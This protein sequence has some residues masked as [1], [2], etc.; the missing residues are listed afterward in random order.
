M[1]S[2]SRTRVVLTT[3]AVAL[4]AMVAA[5][6]SPPPPPPPPVVQAP[7]PPPPITL[8]A[9]VVERASAFRGY[10]ARASQ[11]SPTFQ[12]GEQ[13]QASLKV[14][15]AYETK[16]FMNGAV[17]YAAV[18]ALQDPT[19]VASVREVA[20]NPAQRQEMVNNIFSNPSYATMFKGA[21]S[22]AGLIIDTIGGD[23]L[24]LFM[25][26]KAVKQAAYDVQ[27][28]TWSK[29]TVVDRD[30][31]LASTKSLSTSPALAESADVAVLQQASTG[32]QS[33]GLTPRAAEAPYSPV[34]VRG[35]AVA[36]LAALGAA[37][38]ENLTSIDALSVDP[39]TNSCLNM[40]KLNLY[41]CLAVS[42]PHYEDI[43]C[44]GQHI[45]IDTGACVIKAAGA[46]VPPEPPRVLP[47]K[48]SIATRGAGSNSR[49]A[50]TPAKKPAKKG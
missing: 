22:A 17:A 9:S 19:F 31:R 43:F 11:V 15:A 23:G 38:D 18:L 29:A 8:S 37:G 20:A 24:K 26:G 35:L 12:N 28:S 3:T 21:D 4:A 39:A 1:R 27:K 34:V 45:L 13:I 50:K 16:S 5:C 6:S 7:P 46:T 44:L 47:V 40:A 36:A 14:G 48:E 30:G 32:G 42:K 2:F 33:L 10:M 25:A 41:Q 49:K